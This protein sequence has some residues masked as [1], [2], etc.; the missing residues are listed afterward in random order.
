M[1]ANSDIENRRKDEPYECGICCSTSI[2]EITT[3]RHVNRLLT[4]IPITY[5]ECERCA[6]I[7]HQVLDFSKK[8]NYELQYFDNP[9]RMGSLTKSLNFVIQHFEN[10]N[11]LKVLDIGCSNGNFMLLLQEKGFTAFG[12]DESP[13]AID[14]ARQR[15]LTVRKSVDELEYDQFDFL[16]FSHVL[17]HVISPLNLLQD[18]MDY[19]KSD[20]KVFI[21][22]PSLEL[23]SKGAKCT[24]NNLHPMHIYHFSQESIFHLASKLACSIIAISHHSYLEYPSMMCLLQKIPPLQ[25]SR[26]RFT[27]HLQLEKKTIG[28]KTGE[29]ETLL[30]DWSHLA[31]WG[32]SNEAY[33][34]I[35]QIPK[36]CRAKIILV[37]SDE[38]KIGKTLNLL[39]IHGPNHLQSLDNI[40][41]FVAPTSLRIA[42]NIQQNIH[43]ISIRK[44][45]KIILNCRN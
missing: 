16:V 24:F 1:V 4:E 22:V 17:E 3:L 32:I 21:E 45:Y 8:N 41:F 9:V 42:S 12:V 30:P 11:G 34:L 7:F 28:R 40:L 5:Y 38:S 10:S 6:A 26:I 39:K 31:I 2:C 27:N 29:L 37:D 14:V 19:L 15:G 23:L 44:N 36:E 33:Q 20:G 13:K 18:H 25:Y 43:A 35:R